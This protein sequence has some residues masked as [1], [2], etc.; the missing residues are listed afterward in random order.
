[1]WRGNI[2]SA[3]TNNIIPGDDCNELVKSW[4]YA[5][6]RSSIRTRTLCEA[7]IILF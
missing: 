4:F 2:L 6:V 1:M 5:A 7:P 3:C